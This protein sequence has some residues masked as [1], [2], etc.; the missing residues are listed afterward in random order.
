MAL[1]IIHSHPEIQITLFYMDIQNFGKD[2]D[3]YYA[4]AKN[5]I[6][7]IRGLPGDFYPA[8]DD[9][10]LVSFYDEEI[11]RTTTDDFDMVILSVGITPSASQ[12]SLKDMLGLSLNKDGFLSRP[13]RT[14]EKGIF[15]AGSAGGPMNVSESIT[16]GKRAALEMAKYLKI[17]ADQ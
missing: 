13:E 5:S 17:V 15:V 3:R 4:E 2:F 8:G 1:R 9:S 11:R 6:R 14:R 10:I 7:L 12:S 16:H